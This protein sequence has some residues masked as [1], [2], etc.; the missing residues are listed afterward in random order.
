MDRE[1]LIEV[2]SET[3]VEVRGKNFQI[4][5]EVIPFD[6]LMEMSMM[7]AKSTI[8]PLTFQNRAENCFIALDMASRM[9][10]S[11]MLLMQNLFIIQGKPS[12]SG[13]FISALLRSSPSWRDVTLH[14]VGT[15]NQD[16]WG[17]Y[18]SAIRNS[19]GELVKGATVT[20]SIAKKEGWFQKSGS[21]WQTMPEV[22]L[23]Y[24]AYTWFGRVYAPE[25]LMG[26]Q[27][28]DELEDIQVVSDTVVDPFA[29]GV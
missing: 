9:G 13:Q 7:M 5:R 27:S 3:S 29:G 25:L 17:A 26:L 6:K 24:R 4:A 23:A 14:Y 8:I 21:K 11:P 1:D 2:S 18:V 12:L 19:T 10:I 22:M 20:L 28:S 16:T 15:P